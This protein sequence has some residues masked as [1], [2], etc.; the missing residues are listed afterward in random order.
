M[1]YITSF[2]PLIDRYSLFL[3][4]QFGVLHNGSRSYSGMQQKLAEL[5]QHGKRIAVISNS[6]KRASVNA[7]RIAKFGYGEDLIDDVYTSG[8]L[9]R[10]RLHD[11]TSSH[12]EDRPLRVYYFGNDDDRS[13]LNGL[14]IIEIENP[15]VAD[16]IIIGGMGAQLRT[17]ED[18]RLLSKRCSKC[19]C[20]C[21]LHK[22]GS[23]EFLPRR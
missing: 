16:L 19:R 7:T 17:E 10:S 18:Y 9:A 23:L 13:A 20:A 5:K 4:D 8:E 14:P 3:F 1:E 15:A 11:L 6:G 22:S 21:L 2:T 12:T